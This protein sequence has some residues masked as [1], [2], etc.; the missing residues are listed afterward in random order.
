MRENLV[1]KMYCFCFTIATSVGQAP[2]HVVATRG[3][4]ADHDPLERCGAG[5]EA[6]LYQR[7]LHR[8]I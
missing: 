6:R 4:N 3:V 7:L 2:P 8:F 5:N 1:K